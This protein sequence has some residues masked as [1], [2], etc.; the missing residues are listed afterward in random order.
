MLGMSIVTVN[1]ALQ[2]WRRT[3]AMEFRNGELA[4][5]DWKAG[6]TGRLR[7]ELPATQAAIADVGAAF[8]GFLHRTGPSI[9]IMGLPYSGRMKLEKPISW[10]HGHASL[11]FQHPH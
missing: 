2:T 5:F 1:R 3:G 9:A 7:P 10:D 8:A 6:R 4:V 11:F